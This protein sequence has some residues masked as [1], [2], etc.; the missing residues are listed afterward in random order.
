AAPNATAALP[1]SPPWSPPPHGSDQPQT[2]TT[3]RPQATPA[4]MVSTPAAPAVPADA[5][6]APPA[7]QLLPDLREVVG[8]LLL[9]SHRR[10][11]AMDGCSLATCAW[12]L[13][14]MAVKPSPRWLDRFQAAAFQQAC[15]GNL[16]MHERA[17]MLWAAA[18]AG[19]PLHPDF[20]GGL[21][22]GPALLSSADLCDLGMVVW[23]VARLQAGAPSRG[24]LGA[25]LVVSAREL[26]RTLEAAAALDVQ[27]L[28]GLDAQD[29]QQQQQQQLQRQRGSGVAKSGKAPGSV[30]AR[31]AGG[32][33][34][35]GRVSS[36]SQASARPSPE[37][38]P[39]LPQG[40]SPLSYGTLP[41]LDACLMLAQGLLFLRA[42]P[43]TR[44]WR[45]WLA[46]ACA[47]L[48]RMSLQHCCA[49]LWVVAAAG[50]GGG[51]TGGVAQGGGQLRQM[52][53]ALLAR[54]D[55]LL[56]ERLMREVGS[57]GGDGGAG[58]EWGSG[59]VLERDGSVGA[60]SSN[61]SSSSSR[62][63]SRN[64]GGSRS[65]AQDPALVG[66]LVGLV[67]SLATLVRR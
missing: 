13:A 20:V 4:A 28:E 32:A 33:G 36:S 48:P 24:L 22:P 2:G 59:S 6:T 26:M 40:A 39:V 12:A 27:G 16:G 53:H 61:S 50:A 55:G 1:G 62:G 47:D 5:S 29:M 63:V 9:A 45:L 49:V 64:S 23:G 51:G 37:A 43:P 41:H 46:S 17:M 57:R 42:R 3:A 56:R 11:H 19:W 14:S 21:L 66:N 58:H 60:S 30:R 44:W 31:S 18:R 10:M 15:Q 7:S 65:V 54:C 67:G 8:S 25:M 34:E 38:L 35:M 52:L